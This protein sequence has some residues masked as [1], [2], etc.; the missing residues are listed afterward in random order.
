[1]LLSYA[2]VM[3][4]FIIAY[5]LCMVN[6]TL[7]VNLDKMF[8]SKPCSLALAHDSPLRIEEPTY[9]GIKRVFLKML[10]FYS[11]QSKSIRGAN[12][13]YKRIISR[14]DKPAI[15]DGNFCFSYNFIVISSVHVV[16]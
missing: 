5:M 7:Q 8:W 12:V 13:V 11:E 16:S 3:R 14:V 1:M 4:S 9:E 10:L 2:F 6:H 15:Y